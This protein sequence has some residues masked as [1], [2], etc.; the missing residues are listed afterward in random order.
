MD[1]NLIHFSFIICRYK[2]NCGHRDSL[3]RRMSP[4]VKAVYKSNDCNK[5]MNQRI[6]KFLQDN[7]EEPIIIVGDFNAH[8]GQIG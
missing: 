7:E 6:N 5:E 8:T 2:I 4:Q 3:T 1:K